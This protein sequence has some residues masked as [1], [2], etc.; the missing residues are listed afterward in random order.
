MATHRTRYVKI[1]LFE[2]CSTNLQGG[3]IVGQCGD[4]ILVERPQPKARA[5][6][7]EKKPRKPRAKSAPV[8][9]ATSFPSAVA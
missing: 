8:Q 6:D 9:P 2:P 7:S 5:K 3:V 4:W 1:I